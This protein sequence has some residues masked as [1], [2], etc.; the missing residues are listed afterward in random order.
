MLIPDPIYEELGSAFNIKK[1]LDKIYNLEQ[2][3]YCPTKVQKFLNQHGLDFEDD[4]DD[5]NSRYSD[6]SGL[7]GKFRD[8]DLANQVCI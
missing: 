8:R 6:A 5:G 2:I 1:A 3:G 4:S 7:E